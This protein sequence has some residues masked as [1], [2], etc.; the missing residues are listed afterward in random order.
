MEG[1]LWAAEAEDGLLRGRR[2]I[3]NNQ[4]AQLFT[5]FSLLLPLP[6]HYVIPST[7]LFLLQ[8]NRCPYV[9]FVLHVLA[10]T[11]TSITS[12]LSSLSP[13]LPNTTTIQHAHFCNIAA[14]VSETPPTGDM[15][16]VAARP[17]SGK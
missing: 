5:S 12:S 11:S 1:A 8:K 15:V 16:H 2:R 4:L 14:M 7:L 9:I 10:K 13:P 17:E 6:P 3:A